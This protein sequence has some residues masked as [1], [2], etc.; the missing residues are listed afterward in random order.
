MKKKIHSASTDIAV[1]PT[2]FTTNFLNKSCNIS[3]CL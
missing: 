3:N 1:V 2:Q